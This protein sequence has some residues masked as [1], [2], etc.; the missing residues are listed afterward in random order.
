MMKTVLVSKSKR[1]LALVWLIGIVLPGGLLFVQSLLGFYGDDTTDVTRW[2]IAA[3]SPSGG[4][5][6]AV[7]VADAGTPRGEDR[8]VETLVFQIAL[9][10]S[11]LYLAALWLLILYARAAEGGL[12]QLAKEL[13]GWLSGLQ[14]VVTLVLG[15]FFV[16]RK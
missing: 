4:L 2:F 3:V 13:G 8:R 15:V 14:G 10:V 5:I 6:V 7:L 11:L 1:W 12:P 9:G 16:R